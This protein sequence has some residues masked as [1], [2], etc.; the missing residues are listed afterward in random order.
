ML[1]KI[2]NAMVNLVLLMVLNEAALCGCTIL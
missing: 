1:I 2:M